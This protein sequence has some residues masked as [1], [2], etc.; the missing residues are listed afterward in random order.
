MAL[1]NKLKAIADAIRGKTG[2][3]EEMTLE[4]MATEIAGI[5][6]DGYDKGFD[7]GKQ[8][9]YDK[10]WDTYQDYGN[11]TSYSVYLGAFAGQVWTD[12]LFR[13][14]Y[15][16]VVTS[17]EHMFRQTGITDLTK[18]GVVLDFSQ[19][20][21]F[22]YTFAYSQ[23]KKL[24]SI[25]LSCAANTL[26]T[27]DSFKGDTLHL[28]FSENTVINNAM[29]NSI[30]YLVNLTIEGVIAMS[31]NLSSGSLLSNESVQSIID[32]LKDLTGQTAQKVQF[33][34]NV[35]KNLTDEQMLA[36]TAK[37]WTL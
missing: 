27:F 33:H 32:H 37:N 30:I 1:T 22:N 6:A 25:D 15:P 17:A 20:K 3:T 21:A 18:E 8:S 24:P 28:R 31:I 5:E 4:Q 36:I 10:F 16:L 35:V 29:F 9:E 2:K 7:D 26:S 14:K 34:S 13:P 19:C 23:L 11:K 12:E